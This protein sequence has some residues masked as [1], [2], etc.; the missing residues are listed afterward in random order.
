MSCFKVC[1]LADCSNNEANSN[2][3]NVPLEVAEVIGED[4]DDICNECLEM[5]K[6]EDVGLKIGFDN[7]DDLVLATS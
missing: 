7:F 4:L 5:L 3:Y 2:M 1:D 6:D